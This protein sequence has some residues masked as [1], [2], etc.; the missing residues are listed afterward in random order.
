MVETRGVDGAR[1]GTDGFAE[2]L[3]E[4]EEC[5]GIEC[6]SCTS[7]GVCIIW[8]GESGELGAGEVVAVHGE[9]S[10][11]EGVGREGGGLRAVALI[12]GVC[13]FG[14]QSGFACVL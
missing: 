8:V 13:Y 14:R 4:G 12:E 6:E 3:H 11:E 10:R 7:P 9:E 2:F 5:G 1:F